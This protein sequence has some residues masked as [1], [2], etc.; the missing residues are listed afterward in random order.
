MTLIRILVLILL[1][2]L[3]FYAPAICQISR[4]EA[5]AI[6]G[7]IAYLG[8]LGGNNGRGGV[9]LK[10]YTWKSTRCA[11]GAYLGYHPKD[12][13][14]S[15]RL[16]LIHGELAG[17]DAWIKP[18]KDGDE[19]TRRERNLD[20]RS[21]L[22]EV[23]VMAEIYPTV[24]LEN[25][26]GKGKGKKNKLKPYVSLGVGIFHFNPQGTYTDPSGNS[27]WVDL[28]PLH[29][30]GEGF[31]EY[32]D[33]KMYALTQLC[34]PMG[35]GVT[36]FLDERWSISG[37]IMNIKTFTDYIDDVSTRYIDPSLFYKYL[38]P[39]LAPVADYMSNKSPLRN[40]PGSGYQPGDKRGD[41]GDKDGYIRFEIKV[42]IRLG[43]TFNPWPLSGRPMRY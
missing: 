19:Q 24:W 6:G 27:S 40:T 13:W 16:S 21:A 12:D 4:W 14:L 15:L 9:L 42:G 25:G 43:K 33:R 22:D 31:P 10:D 1:L 3:G 2:I 26:S 11:Q 36:Y 17:D 39:S 28:R 41:P 38:S 5:G 34:I 35:T 23:A 18:G 32:P 29:T 37:E 8:D 20:F 30:E 7:P